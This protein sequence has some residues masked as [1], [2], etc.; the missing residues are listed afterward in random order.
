M[1]NEKFIKVGERLEEL[2]NKVVSV[3]KWID[4]PET[5]FTAGQLQSFEENDFAAIT[6]EYYEFLNS[7]GFGDVLKDECEKVKQAIEYFT[8][9]GNFEDDVLKMI[10]YSVTCLRTLYNDIDLLRDKFQIYSQIIEDISGA[11]VW[12]KENEVV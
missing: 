9:I 2:L 12:V 1:K 7:F 11:I 8:T 5:K 10:E 4:N 6:K 3:Y